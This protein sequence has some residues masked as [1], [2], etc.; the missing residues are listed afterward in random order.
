MNF[1]AL[2][3]TA[4]IATTSIFAAPQAEASTCFHLPSGDATI[5]NTYQGTNRYGSVYTL[6]YNTD[7]GSD[8]GMTVTCRGSHVVDWQSEGNMSYSHLDALANYFCGL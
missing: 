3:A 2:A 6:G 5:C 4:L 1:K 7:R 8:T